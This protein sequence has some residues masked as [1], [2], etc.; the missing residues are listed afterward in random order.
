M[1]DTFEIISLNDIYKLEDTQWLIKDILPN[2]STIILYGPSGCGKTFVTLDLCLHVS[3]NMKWL[4]KEIIVKGIV[5]YCIAEGINGISNRIKAWHYYHNIESGTP[6]IILPIDTIT[7]NDIENINRMIKTLDKIKLKYKLDISLI[8]IDTLSKATIGYDENSAK[9]MGEFFYHFDIIKKYFNTSILFVHHS[10]KSSFKGMRGSS[11]LIGTADTII[12]L[13]NCNN[14]IFCNI[15]KQKDGNTSKFQ[16]LLGKYNHTLVVKKEDNK[17]VIK[18]HNV[19]LDNKITDVEITRL[20]K[21]KKSLEEIA[22]ILNSDI[23]TI[24]KIYRKI[25][26]KN[27]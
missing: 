14:R 10:G 22:K 8:V 23:E 26:F 16:L 11:Y 12:N 24:N 2:N 6:F 5:V 19:I 3:H 17:L 13:N 7:F 20:L 21:D 4:G 18:N 1:D 9:D 15:E 25:I 27:S